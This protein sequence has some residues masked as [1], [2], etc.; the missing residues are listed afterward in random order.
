MPKYF[1]K[2]FVQFANSI[3]QMAGTFAGTPLCKVLEDSADEIASVAYNRKYELNYQGNELPID[4]YIDSNIK[5][6]LDKN[7]KKIK[8]VGE[9]QNFKEGSIQKNLY[10]NIVFTFD[11]FIKDTYGLSSDN[12]IAQ[13]YVGV[14][15]TNKWANTNLTIKVDEKEYEWLPQGIKQG[16][17]LRQ[18]LE[19]AKYT[20]KEID[21]SYQKNKM[22]ELIDASRDY[23]ESVIQMKNI[24]KLGGTVSDDVRA[25]LIKKAERLKKAIVDTRAA[26][27]KN[28]EVAMRMYADGKYVDDFVLNGG[29]SLASDLDAINSEIIFYKSALPMSAMDEYLEL[30]STVDDLYKSTNM[31]GLSNLDK[32]GEVIEAIEELKGEVE[33][34]ASEDANIFG[35]NEWAVSV[36]EKIANLKTKYDEFVKGLDNGNNIPDVQGDPAQK[37]YLTTT[38]DPVN[39]SFTKAIENLSNS[40][41]HDVLINLGKRGADNYKNQYISDINAFRSAQK[42]IGDKLTEY[43]KQLG[44]QGSKINT[45]LDDAIKACKINSGN[46]AAHTFEYLNKLKNVLPKNAN[47]NRNQQKS[48]FDELPEDALD[49]LKLYDGYTKLETF[50][51]ENVSEQGRLNYA[52]ALEKL[53]KNVTIYDTSGEKVRNLVQKLKNKK[54]SIADLSKDL[55]NVR[56]NLSENKLVIEYDLDSKGQEY[57]KKY[58][59]NAPEETK[60][61]LADLS[62]YVGNAAEYVRVKGVNMHKQG[63]AADLSL[64]MQIKVAERPAGAYLQDAL[65]KFNTRRSKIFGKGDNYDPSIGKES[66]EH[67]KARL[68]VN[69]FKDEKLKLDRIDISLNQEEWIKQA[70]VVLRKINDAKFAM[71]EY[72]VDKGYAANTPAGQAR[73]DG[74]LDV[75]RECSYVGVEIRNKFIKNNIAEFIKGDPDAL[76]LER[77]LSTLNHTERTKTNVINP[78]NFNDLKNKII[79]VKDDVSNKIANKKSSKTSSKTKDNAKKED[80]FINNYL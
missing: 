33:Q 27:N 47:K 11:G 34:L 71:H 42:A 43:K 30:K 52:E 23:H 21:D 40:Y 63:I 3:S 56:K 68:A 37:R 25:E 67:R 5:G 50:L 51:K 41:N 17:N 16:S 65:D 75:Q 15:I 70:N 7:L 8:E 49:S 46:S 14:K 9:K 55:D 18:S 58:G 32:S 36:N 73:I 69:D 12:P 20:L 79:N 39:G 59:A 35:N 28:D 44:D 31:K 74:A 64:E 19:K 77:N 80:N 62:D 4:F 60:V 48:E 38:L 6:I 1:L 57:Y 72:L 76:G 13:D 53:E 61:S 66:P 78:T 26:A 54:I 10:D 24:L 45:A 22:P 2:D 29:R